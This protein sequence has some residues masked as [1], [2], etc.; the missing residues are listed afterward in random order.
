MVLELA[1]RNTTHRASTESTM[2]QE[3]NTLKNVYQ[4]E[5]TRYLGN[6]PQNH[7]KPWISHSTMR[8]IE[9]RQET[10]LGRRVEEQLYLNKEIKREARRDKRKFFKK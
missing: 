3:W 6:Q 8:F 7:Q 10:R 4:L 5:Q 9:A 1:N 2:D